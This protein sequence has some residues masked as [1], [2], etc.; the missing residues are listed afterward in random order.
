MFTKEMLLKREKSILKDYAAKNS[1]EFL[2]KRKELEVET[3][4]R[5]ETRLP[6]QRDRDR[7]IHS[8]AFRRLMHKTQ[9]FNANK[10]DHFRNRLTH[11]LEVSQ[12]AR[13]IGKVLGLNEELIEAISLGHD[14]GHT[15]FGHIGERTL[16]LIISGQMFKKDIEINIP[17]FG[18]F[19]HNFQSLQVV[20]NLEKSSYGRNGMN[21]TLAV[22]EGILK[23]TGRKIKI[24]K[25][26]ERKRIAQEINYTSLD[27][28]NINIDLPSF[29]LE[30]QV[31]AIADEIA[32]CTHDLED[33]LRAK[34][35]RLEDI[36]EAPLIKRIRE[37]YDI[38]LNNLYETVDV[39]NV[40]IKFMVGY[41]IEDVCKSTIANLKQ[42]YPDEN[43]PTF[44]DN[45]DVYKTEIVTFSKEIKEMTD[46]FLKL[47]TKLVISSELVS[48]ADSKA[49]Y[50]ICKLFKAYYKHPQQLPEYILK[51][52]FNKKRKEFDRSVINDLVFDLQNDPEFIR[53]IC[54]HIAGMTDQYAARQYLELYEPEYY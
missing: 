21:L 30:G 49:E 29:T 8:R 39:R 18:G 25:V 16:H 17:N 41:L 7:I 38:S 33:G 37:A 35:I 42:Q 13:S 31:V 4:A 23:H 51:K 24:Y 47:I 12:I 46:E 40:L 43:Y 5:F 22:R 20:D 26:G 3:K 14:L 36:K 54:D 10:G 11:T 50:M 52:Y 6:F 2:T 48:K 1:S 15:P 9:I 32:Q 34:I 19:K 53:S 44:M 27:L 28:T 45:N